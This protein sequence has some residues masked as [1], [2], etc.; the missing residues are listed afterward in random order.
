LL[1]LINIDMWK[2]IALIRTSVPPFSIKILFEAFLVWNQL[3]TRADTCVV[4]Y[5]LL[6]NVLIY[7][8]EVNSS[9]KF[10]LIL[11]FKIA[12]N[13]VTSLSRF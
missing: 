9:T 5:S 3:A 10:Y 7:E 8:H 1:D 12:L 2:K 11:Q 4:F 13:F 6:C